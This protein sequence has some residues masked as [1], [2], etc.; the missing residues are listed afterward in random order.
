MKKL[1]VLLLSLVPL[2]LQAQKADFRLMSFNIERGDLSEGIGL[3]WSTRKPAALA[4]LQY[5]QPDLLGVQ[6]CNSIQRDDILAVM[7]YRHIGVAVDGSA[8]EHPKTSANFIFYN[9]EVF[10]LLDD[11]QFWFSFYPDSVGVYTW[12]AKKPR[13]ATWGRFRHIATGRE[14][15]YINNH[16]Q[17]GLDAVINRSMTVMELLSRMR[18]LNPDGLP[19]IFTG[20][21]NSRG[22]ESYYAPLRQEM[23]HAADTCPV[24]DLGITHG[25]YK[26]KVGTDAQGQIDHIFYSGA[27]EG[28]VFGVDR[29]DYA[30]LEFVSDH[31]PVYCDLRFTDSAPEKKETYW[32]DLKPSDGD[33]TIKAGT[34]NLF[35]TKERDERGA[36]SWNSVKDGVVDVIASLGTDLLGLQEMTEPMLRDLQKMLKARLGKGYKLWAAFSDPNPEAPG[37]EAVGLL[38]NAERFSLSRQQQVW[39]R[40]GEFEAPAK[41]WGDEYR[42]ILTAVVKDKVTGRRFFVITGKG[43]KGENPVKYEGNVVKTIEKELNVDGLPC[44]LLWDMNTSPRGNVWISL[45]NFWTDTFALMY[46]FPDTVFATRIGKDDFEGNTPKDWSIRYD[47]VGISRYV[48]NGIIITEN[49]VHRETRGMDPVPSDHYPVTATLIFTK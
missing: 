16:W 44:L 32:F 42:S 28:L 19:M 27:L 6:E 41:P 3:G 43:C 7:P 10:E 39:I 18:E 25:G 13:S 46:P 48:E 23:Q 11:G 38:Y 49:T 8:D 5:R 47:I 20:D 4:M 34:W 37:R 30:G 24:T 31:F 26:R 36:P 40:A 14:F 17:N 12:I 22:I 29:E 9:P 1:I 15:V 33:Y 45:L 35:S 21:L 2:A